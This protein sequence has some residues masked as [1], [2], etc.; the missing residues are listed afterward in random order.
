MY[1]QVGLESQMLIEQ[2]SHQQ[3]DVGN[4][5]QSA[6]VTV[7]SCMLLQVVKKL[8]ENGVKLIALRCAGYDRVDIA[9]CE[10][11]GIKVRWH[12]DSADGALG[13]SA[14]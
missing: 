4:L 10:E 14:V 7:G 6:N 9:A 11:H 8:A 5:Q 12:P 13:S 2:P 1:L 3:H